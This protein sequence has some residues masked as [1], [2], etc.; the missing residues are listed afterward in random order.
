MSALARLA[1]FRKHCFA[2]LREK[3][4]LLLPAADIWTSGAEIVAVLPEE[5]KSALLPG[6][7]K[8]RVK[9]RWKL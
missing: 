6:K 7:E 2:Y 1:P 4:D 8:G 3:R 5:L 9:T